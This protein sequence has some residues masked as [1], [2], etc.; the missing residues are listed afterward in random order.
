SESADRYR[1]LDA[2]VY[3]LATTLAIVADG[4]KSEAEISARL[5]ITIVTAIV[6]PS[7]RPSPRTIAPT[8]PERAIGNT[9]VRMASQRVAPRASAPS[10]NT[11]GTARITSRET[12][13]IVGR[14]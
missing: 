12:E 8:I 5:P 6:S 1:S 9:P 13:A 14:I 3:S 2:S 4:A 10:R 11:V 7:A